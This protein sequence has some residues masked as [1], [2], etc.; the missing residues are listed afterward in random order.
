MNTFENPPVRD[1]LGREL[2]HDE[3]ELIDLYNRL[4]QLSEREDIAPC[5]SMNAKQAMVMLWNACNDLGLIY[6]ETDTD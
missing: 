2:D 6:E 3:R 1:L 4:R 5:I